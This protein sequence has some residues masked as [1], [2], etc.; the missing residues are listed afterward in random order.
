MISLNP[1]LFV[2]YKCT[3]RQLGLAHEIFVLLTRHE[4]I[5]G[6]NL[7]WPILPIWNFPVGP[8]RKS[9][10]NGNLYCPSL[11]DQD[12]WILASFF[13]AFCFF[14][15]TSS[16]SIKTQVKLGKYPATVYIWTLHLVN[17]AYILN[18]GLTF[19]C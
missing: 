8:A 18:S 12:G 10:P 17:N 14:T 5:P 15:S 2:I 13:F 6:M 11:F 19:Y 16:W 9:S 1:F 4:P 3:N 7:R